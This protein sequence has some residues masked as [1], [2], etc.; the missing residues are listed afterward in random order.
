MCVASVSVLSSLPFLATLG[1]AVGV[2]AVAIALP[3]I[4]V[5]VLAGVPLAA[6][7]AREAIEA[8]AAEGDVAAREILVW[9]GQP[10]GPPAALAVGLGR[11][12]L[13]ILL[14]DALLG[15]LPPRSVAAVCAHE[16]AHARRRHGLYYLTFLL[17]FLLSVGSLSLAL[18]QSLDET[19]SWL[20]P[21]ALVAC[22]S[23]LVWGVLLP[24][25]SRSFEREADLLG[26]ETSGWTPY[27]CALRRLCDIHPARAARRGWLHP[28][29]DD[30][31]R[32]L[33]SLRASGARRLRL[34]R[35]CLSL[36]LGIVSWL[37]A[38][39][40]L[41]VASVALG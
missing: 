36:R 25:V 37:A 22:A 27:L 13:R 30:R 18:D 21:A 31:L 34:R 15:A 3:R 28:S 1:G 16:L 35:R 14:N 20:A 5:W 4:L 38:A 7:R 24:P 19:A 41:F 26:A 40:G 2:I 17:A 10:D 33:E 6:G 32:S 8:L 39:A 11:R 12:S 23:L 29:L 9:S